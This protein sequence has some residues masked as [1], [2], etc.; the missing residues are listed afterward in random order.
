MK[1]KNI[2]QKEKDKNRRLSLL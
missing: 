1:Q 2:T